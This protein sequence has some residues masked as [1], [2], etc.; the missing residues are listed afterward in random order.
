MDGSD[1][2]E[3]AS[4]DRPEVVALWKLVFADDPPHNAPERVIER[5]LRVQRDL[6]LVAVSHGRVVGTVLGG[7]DGFRG[8]VYHL[9][10]HPDHRLNGFGRR[11]MQ[12]L[13]IRIRQRGCP[14]LN[15]QVR[16]ENA[17]IRTFYERLGYGVEERLSMGK[18]LG[19]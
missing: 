5:K 15:L 11:L 18:V 13:E 3:Y 12:A 10:V 17:G 7:Y 6:F 9:A 14:K 8:W 1:V 2:R 16:A 4:T 19:E